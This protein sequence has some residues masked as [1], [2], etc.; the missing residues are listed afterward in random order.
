M[1]AG[2]DY[3][4]GTTNRDPA[5]G[6]RYGVISQHGVSQAWRDSA[7][8]DYGAATCPDCKFR[9]NHAKIVSTNA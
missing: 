9:R 7:E 5:T 8:P 4:F 3:G 6:M 2:I 1:G